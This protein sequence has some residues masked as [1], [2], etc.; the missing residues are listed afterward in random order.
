MSFARPFAYNPIPPNS[1]ISGTTQVGD[2]AV[3]FPLTGFT[4]TPQYW[5]GPDEDLGY[6]IAAETLPIL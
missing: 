2:L 3:G 6:V 5:N 1:L 4:N